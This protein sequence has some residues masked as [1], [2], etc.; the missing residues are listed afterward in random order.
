MEG[1]LWA[2]TAN[3]GLNKFD[4]ITGK[5]IHYKH[6][7]DNTGSIANDSVWVLMKDRFGVLWV[8]TQGGGLDSFDRATE[9]FIHHEGLNSTYINAI[10]ERKLE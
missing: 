7:P 3:G 2:G 10:Y 5:F 4:R 6:D 9:V 1:V 8:G